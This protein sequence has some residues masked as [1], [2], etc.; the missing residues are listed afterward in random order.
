MITG[1]VVSSTVSCV[2]VVIEL[3]QS[4]V[5]MKVTF[6]LTHPIPS[7]PS[8][9]PDKKGVPQLSVNVAPFPLVK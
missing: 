2:V 6:A 9:K 5:N 7:S 3:L 1:G 4:S 8:I